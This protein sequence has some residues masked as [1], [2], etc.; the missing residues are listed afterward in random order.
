MAETTVNGLTVAA[1]VARLADREQELIA[2]RY[3]SDLTARQIADLLGMRTNT[4][5][6]ALHRALAHLRAFLAPEPAAGERPVSSLRDV[7]V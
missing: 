2:L 3:A 7:R 6:V 5:E 1:A 4:V